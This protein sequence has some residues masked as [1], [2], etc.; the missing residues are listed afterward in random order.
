MAH[1]QA[2]A[3]EG[4]DQDDQFAIRIF[5]RAEDGRSVC[6]GT[7][8]QPFF[9]IKPKKF[10]K[11]LLEFV[12]TKCW[13]AE[14]KRA[15]DLW[16][17]QN[18]ELRDFIQVTFKTH[19][20]L[21]GLAWSIENA[22]WPELAGCRVYES[23]IDPVLRFMHVSGCSSTGWIDPGLCEPDTETTCDINL[24]APNWRFISPL[25]RDDIAPLK[26]MSFDIECY[27]STGAFPDPRNPHDVVFQIGMT[28]KAFGK[29]G[30]I[31][32]KCL[33]LKNT[34][35]DD[36]E[37]FNTERELLDAFQKYLVKV[38]PDI[39]TGWN[40][41]GFDLEFLHFRAVLNGA[42]TVWGRIKGVSID[43]VVEKNLSS[44][45]LGNNLLKMTPM[46]GRYVFDLFQ[47]VKREHKL[48]SYSLNNVS[49]HFLKDQKNDMPVKEIFSRY[50]EGDPERLGEVA[51]YCIKDTELPHALMEKLCQIQNV[52][53]MAKA[54][55]VPLAFL[56]ERGQQIK[57]F[58]Q[59]AKKARELNFIIPTFQRSPLG[60]PGG[61]DEGYQGATV[62]EAQT[63]AYYGPIT[64]LDFASLYPSIMCAHNLCYSTLVMDPK[65]DNLPGVEY[66]QYGP[67]RFAQN[68]PSLLPVIL[69][70]LKAF[71]KKAKKLMA[72][73]EGTQMEAIYNGQ[74]LAYKIS[75]NSIYGFTGA[76]K[77]MLPCVAIASTVTMRGRQMIEETKN[78][79]EEHF[80][81]AKVRYGDSVMPG[82]PVL[83][84]TNGGVSV[85]T[86]E[87]LGVDW[88]D[89][90][91]FLKQGT[92]KEESTLSE[93]ET[94]T[95]DGWKPIKRVIRHKCSKKIYR[96]LTHT[97]LVDVTEDH[98]LLGP[99]LSLIKPCDT[100]VG[101]Q[102]F[103]SFPYLSPPSDSCSYEQAFI[104]G[105]FVGDGSCGYYLC[106]S[107]SKATWAIN[108][109]DKALLEKCQVMC[110]AIHPEYEFVIMDTLESSGVYKLSP[111]G[112]SVVDLARKY[113]DDCYDGQSKKVPLTA[114]GNPE[115]FL[116]GLWASDGCRRD[117]E[118]GGCRRIDTKNQVTA[119]WY[120]ILLRHIGFNVSLN[121]RTDKPNVFRLTWTNSAFRKQ[122][123]AIKKIAVLH[124]SWDGFVYDL[125]T[126]AGTFQAGVGQMIVKNT[127]SVMVEFDVQGRKGQEAIDYSWEQGEM[128]AEQCTK[129]FK[130]PNDLE[131][132][133]VYC[134]YFLYSKKRYAAKMFEKKGDSVVFKKIDV[135]GLQVVR[136]DSCPFVRET[137]KKL[138]GMILESS[139]PTPVIEEARGAARTLIQGKVPMEK[140]LMSKQLAS[141]YKVPMAHVTVRDKI[142]SRAPGSEPQQ[143]DRVAFVIV[144]GD[145]KMFEKAEDPSWVTEKNLTLDYQYYFSNQLK[146][147]VQDLLEPLINADVIFDKKFL[148][149]TESTEEVKARK[150]FLARF[151]G[152]IKAP[153]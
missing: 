2:I 27:S 150:A 117:N 66:E 71:R 94:W 53:E 59:M 97:G 24:W 4:Q 50:A 122:P 43:K 5:G 120:Y 54:C 112:G 58:S 6:L 16:G 22:K 132:E 130:A 77:G 133:K 49:K 41:F 51:A 128:A 60:G 152:G 134:P 116:E 104:Y 103:H 18:G 90:P 96:V 44:S 102:L 52:V 147:P 39:L 75:M 85:R 140:L 11:E 138:L 92:D 141:A 137:L 38:D 149:K 148:V 37:S 108:N 121:S 40:I 82:T 113:R 68:V 3:W 29:E 99:D 36:I 46:K 115:A 107:G 48:E 129:L 61:A 26:I 91:G 74:Q 55:W 87:T 123:F 64:A 28:V 125:E 136:R 83:V 33:C 81:G 76:S 101:Q 80:P 143:G 42:S 32:R 9:Y 89:Y 17:F 131:L 151:A 19:R 144:K 45:A 110:K 145:G 105:M 25:A 15:K 109:A 98:S 135:K 79:V 14:V 23:N 153:A 111:R 118:V 93:I 70:D 78:Y 65:Y 86:I 114:F 62:L 124:D 100:R 20:S 139:D 142:K 88:S 63:G 95:H 69:T 31:D 67:H 21:R 7:P 106:P 13:K 84:R 35:G 56:S 57:V 8:F 30:W 119:Q 73:T 1:F 126:E 12:K 146:K 127:D 10:T 72:Q 34:V 47:D